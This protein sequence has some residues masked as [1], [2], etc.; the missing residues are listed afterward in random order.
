MFCMHI[1]KRNSS[2]L[3]C[4]LVYWWGRIEKSELR[5]RIFL[6]RSSVAIALFKAF[7]ALNYRSKHYTSWGKDAWKTTQKGMR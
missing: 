2:A 6:D 3:Y 4:C 1:K 7:L 5:P